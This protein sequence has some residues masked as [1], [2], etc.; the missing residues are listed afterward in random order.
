MCA[1]ILELPEWATA[2]SVASE[3]EEEDLEGAEKTSLSE[4]KALVKVKEIK[5]TKEQKARLQ[6]QQQQLQKKEKKHQTMTPR[7]KEVGYAA[8]L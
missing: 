7:Q 4:P 6:Q 1:S 8:L 2:E 3:E 5:V